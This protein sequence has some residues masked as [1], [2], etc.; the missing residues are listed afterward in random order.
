VRGALQDKK[1]R[2]VATSAPKRSPVFPD[3]PTV[4]EAGVAGYEVTSWNGLFAPAGTPPPVV[5]TINKTMREILAD[6]GL[7]K[8]YLELGVDAKAS[9]PDELKARLVADIKKWSE[10]IERAGIPKQ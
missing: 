2:A 9:S 3:V 8:R 10:V 7:K 5:D 4:Q 1:I 6:E